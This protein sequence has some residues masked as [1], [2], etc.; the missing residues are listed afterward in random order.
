[1]NGEIFNVTNQTATYTGRGTGISPKYSVQI[2]ISGTTFNVDVKLQ[3]SLDEVNWIDINGA[4]SL[5]ISADRNIL[6]D[7]ASGS[8]KYTRAIIT[9]NSGTYDASMYTSSGDQ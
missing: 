7:I 6:F 5:S 2:N 4:E 8:H 1:M 9:R 3:S